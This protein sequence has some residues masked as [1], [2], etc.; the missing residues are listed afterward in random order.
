MINTMEIKALN[1]NR[2]ALID[3]FVYPLISRYNLHIRKNGFLNFEV[4][5]NYYEEGYRTVMLSRLILHKLGI[6]ALS[7][8]LKI[9]HKNFNS[10]HCFVDNLEPLTN[11]DNVRI[12]R[13][14]KYRGI[15]WHKERGKWE[16]KIGFARK[17]FHVGYFHNIEEAYQARIKFCEDNK[18]RAY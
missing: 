2:Y 13:G 15:F 8:P 9:H 3:E 17:I 10:S 5:I 7:S 16:V 4:S 14:G 1:C 12:G 18:I 11:A 6:L